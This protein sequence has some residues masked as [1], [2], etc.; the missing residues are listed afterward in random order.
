MYLIGL[1]LEIYVLNAEDQE[2]EHF[3][4]IFPA[5]RQQYSLISETWHKSTQK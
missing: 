2:E 1:S 5:A 3:I 4:T